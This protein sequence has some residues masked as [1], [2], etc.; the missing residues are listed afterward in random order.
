MVALILLSDELSDEYWNA[1]KIFRSIY[2]HYCYSRTSDAAKV[3]RLLKVYKV[4]KRYRPQ[5]TQEK[6]L[7]ATAGVYFEAMRWREVQVRDAINIIEP[8]IGTGIVSLKDLAKAILVLEKPWS[9]CL[10]DSGYDDGFRATGEED[11]TI[12][13]VLNE[14]FGKVVRIYGNGKGG[15]RPRVKNKCLL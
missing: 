9:G 14:A 6:L 4:F 13:L 15:R 10:S 11:K 1:K 5:A 8:R 3:R 12:D 7:K 2:D